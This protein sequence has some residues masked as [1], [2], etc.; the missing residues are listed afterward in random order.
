MT[1]IIKYFVLAFAGVF[2]FSCGQTDQS[3]KVISVTIEPQRYFV[4]QLVDSLFKV[5]TVVPAG[6]SPET[7]DPSPV[8]IANLSKSTA[9]FAI[10]HIGFETQW[11]DKIRKNHPDLPVYDT[12]LGLELIETG[13]DADDTHEHK[14]SCCEGHEQDN[15][16][17]THEHSEDCDHEHG[18]ECDHDHQH[19]ETCSHGHHH[20]PVDPHT[21]SSPKQ[22]KLIVRNMCKA[23]IAVDPANEAVYK[24][25]LSALEKEIAVT[26]SILTDL[27]AKATSKSFIIYHPALTYLARDYGL[28][29]YCMEADGKEPSP[30]QLQFLS[31]IAK[32]SGIKVVFIQEEFDK[33][34]AETIAKETGA[35]LVSIDPLSY[36]WSE[37]LIRIAK[38]IANE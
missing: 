34:N 12:S 32:N 36:Q 13:G 16:G 35:K 38:A 15:E 18:E 24:K 11:L 19:G 5:Q 26:D 10:G 8:Q 29:Q 25:N 21:W 23:L 2:F 37:E 27:F 9:Y 20:G 14:D 7:Y 30:S 31:T 1:K 33:K 28:T 4:E 3:E 22:M 17:D 6:T